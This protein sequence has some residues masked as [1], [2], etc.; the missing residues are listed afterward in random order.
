MRE[1]ALSPLHLVLLSDQE[2]KFSTYELEALAVLFGVEKFRMYVEHVEFDLETD[3]QALSWVLARPRRT[4][5]LAR[6]AVC[7][8]EFKFVPHHIRGT[9]NITADTQSRMFQ[10][11]GKTET[12]SKLPESP[13][14]A[15]VLLDLP[16]AF[17]KM[18]QHQ[19]DDPVL[20]DIIDRLSKGE[21]ISKYVVNKGVLY[22]RSRSDRKLKIVVPQL[23]V[24][25]IFKYFHE[26]SF[27]GHLGVFKTR[28]KI[29]QNFIWLGMNADIRAKPV[30]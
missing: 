26:S 6:W 2:R 3:N 18:G 11:P 10:D 9:Q 14:I 12:S 4:G 17:E 20:R 8:S 19:S 24:P 28:Q 5:R 1:D 15:P 22:C 13:V 16:L 21:Q 23:L 30:P 29:R 7:L 27:G 25:L